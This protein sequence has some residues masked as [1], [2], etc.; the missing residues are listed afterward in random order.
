MVYE[1]MKMNATVRNLYASTILELRAFFA[2]IIGRMS[3]AAK[4]RKMAAQFLIMIM[5]SILFCKSASADI[6][7]SE[8]RKLAILS[9]ASYATQTQRR[10]V[11]DPFDAKDV[12]IDDETYS[13]IK[14]KSSPTGFFS[15]AYENESTGE[16]IIVYRG[17]D[18]GVTFDVCYAPGK[19][20][21]E[22]LPSFFRVI[23]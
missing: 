11:Y 21:I 19:Q 13:P 14:W 23:I 15:V 2:N 8:Q 5:S 17:T 16:I 12:E 3:M 1:K 18:V 22:N 7:I 4:K 6:S 9:E 20:F 10:F